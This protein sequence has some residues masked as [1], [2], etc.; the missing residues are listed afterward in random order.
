MKEQIIELLKTGEKSLKEIYAIMPEKNK[1]NIRACINIAVKK[2]HI[3]RI[4]KGVYS[5]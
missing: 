3:K 1:D 5:L 4:R 2:N